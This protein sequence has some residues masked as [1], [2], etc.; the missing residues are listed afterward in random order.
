M[1]PR[2]EDQ[3]WQ[4]QLE[5]NQRTFGKLEE[6]SLRLEKHAIEIALM[7]RD[8]ENL[9]KQVSASSN[10]WINFFIAII[11]SAAIAFVLSYSGLKK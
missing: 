3:R 1:P 7:L 9:T 11:T 5:F 8:L 4:S 10:R 6:I 2:N